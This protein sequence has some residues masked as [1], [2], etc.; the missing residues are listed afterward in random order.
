[1][2]ETVPYNSYYIQQPP[3]SAN[4]LLCVL[5]VI[6]SPPE[7]SSSEPTHRQVHF[8]LEYFSHPRPDEAPTKPRRS[9]SLQTAQEKQFSVPHVGSLKKAFRVTIP[10]NY[11]FGSQPP[12]HPSL[13]VCLAGKS[14]PFV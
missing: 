9:P 7:S 2:K 8:T 6:A 12:R 14:S 13:D 5:R 3:L 10:K 1:M 11:F 4:F